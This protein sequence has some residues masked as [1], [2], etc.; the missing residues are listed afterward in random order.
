MGEHLHL[1]FPTHLPDYLCTTGYSY[2]WEATALNNNG[3][4]RANRY[5]Y[6]DVYETD[7]DGKLHCESGPALRCTLSNGEKVEKYFIHGVEVSLADLPNL[8]LDLD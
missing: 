8:T 4:T 2:A 7:A 5:M 3:V 1:R 6:R